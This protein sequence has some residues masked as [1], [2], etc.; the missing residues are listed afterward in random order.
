VQ[1]SPVTRTRT[2]ECP[3]EP[4][5]TAVA[6][7][8]RWRGCS[9]GIRRHRTGPRVP[10]IA[11]RLP[12]VHSAAVSV[13]G[14]STPAHNSRSRGCGQSA[15]HRCS[16]IVPEGSDQVAA[17]G[18]RESS[19]RAASVAQRE[20][21]GGRTDR[22]QVL[23]PV[24]LHPVRIAASPADVAV[25]QLRSGDP[26]PAAA[27]LQHLEHDGR[28]GVGVGPD[29]PRKTTPRVRQSPT[30]APGPSRAIAKAGLP[31]PRDQGWVAKPNDQPAAQ[32]AT[33]PRSRF[34]RR[35]G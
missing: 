18:D 17:D 14:R 6:W 5:E 30:R 16:R 27:A 10:C 33:A 13:S 32:P 8:D 29:Q 7:C 9:R 28:A 20:P 21:V 31:D 24:H 19:Q 3:A 15:A 25:G 1:G 35:C 4:A 34:L 22:K 12:P 26:E 11:I 2:P 23:D